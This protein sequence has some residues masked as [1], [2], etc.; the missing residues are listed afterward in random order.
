MINLLTPRKSARSGGFRAV[1]ARLSESI[2]EFRAPVPAP[3]VV[4]P[5]TSEFFTEQEMPPAEDIA[6][7][8][9]LYFRACD[10]ARSADRAKRKAKGILS[11][12]RVGTYSGWEITREPSGRTVA[13]LDEIKRIFKA[14]GLG[15]IPV[16]ASAPSLKVRRVELDLNPEAVEQ[17]LNTLA[18]AR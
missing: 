15:P 4:E 3:A 1:L 18:G 6:E 13:D 11:K 14:N 17:E 5:D 12:L 8:A 9:R 16:K 10:E 2:A 7:A